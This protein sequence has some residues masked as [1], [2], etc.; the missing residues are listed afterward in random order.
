M[1]QNYMPL[2]PI[3]IRERV[4][5]VF[6]EHG[7]LDMINQAFVITDAQ[8]TRTQI[9]IQRPHHTL[10]AAAQTASTLGGRMF[11][12]AEIAEI[13]DPI[14]RPP[15]RIGAYGKAWMIDLGATRAKRGTTPDQDGCL[16]IWI[17]EAP[18]AHPVWH[19]YAIT[20][21]H[22]RPLADN[23]QTK[24]YLNGAT[25]EMWVDALD[26]DGKREMIIDGGFFGP[27]TC[28]PLRPTNFG[29]QFVET[30][31]VAAAR[32][33]E[34][35]VQQI[36]DGVLSPDTDFIQQWMHLF[37]D[38]MIKG[39][40]A[41]AGATTIIFGGRESNGREPGA[42][43]GTDHFARIDAKPVNTILV[44][45]DITLADAYVVHQAVRGIV[46]LICRVEDARTGS[47]LLTQWRDPI[48]AS[49]FQRRQGEALWLLEEVLAGRVPRPAPNQISNI[50]DSVEAQRKA[51]REMP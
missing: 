10:D 46:G 5:I 50:S 38:N 44:F 29:A 6:L 22:L 34:A 33:I 42:M 35:A 51:Q 49:E 27:D 28:Q 7:R 13:K 37:G 41:Q 25:H 40:K 11:G 21:I 26:P 4:S 36:C 12:P 20:L 19:S 17:V 47:G 15:H 1:Q 31:D 9:P 32:R 8:G 48:P 39:E 45:D 3:P 43:T 24:F 2:K 16:S 14:A 18:W 23:R 30:G